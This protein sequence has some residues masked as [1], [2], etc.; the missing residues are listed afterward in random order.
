MCKAWQ[1][2]CKWLFRVAWQCLVA[3][4]KEEDSDPPQYVN[5][6]SSK[7]LCHTDFEAVLPCFANIR[8]LQH[9]GFISWTK[10]VNQWS[11]IPLPST[12]ISPRASLCEASWMDWPKDMAMQCRLRGS[13]ILRMGRC[14]E[15]A[16]KMEKLRPRT[17]MLM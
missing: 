5:L 1:V 16:L 14:R 11:Q 17:G 4:T 15:V 9:A 13:P 8:I 12:S 7:I 6:V 2:N 10:S 3:R